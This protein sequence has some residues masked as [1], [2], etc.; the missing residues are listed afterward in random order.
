MSVFNLIICV[1]KHLQYFDK[2][3]FFRKVDGSFAVA[4][5]TVVL[6]KKLIKEIEWKT[7]Q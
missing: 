1:R 5:L 4:T 6:L 3:Y 7:A 2:I